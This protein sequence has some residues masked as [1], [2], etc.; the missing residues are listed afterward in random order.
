MPGA[1]IITLWIVTWFAIAYF[2]Y[3]LHF[4]RRI[5]ARAASGESEL[6]SMPTICLQIPLYNEPSHAATCL[7]ACAQI[8]WSVEKIE[9][10]VLDDSNDHTPFLIEEEIQ[11][12][13]A[14]SPRLS[15]KH[16]RRTERVGY[17]AGALDAGLRQ[18]S[19]EFIAIFDCD[20]RPHEAFLQQLMPSLLNDPTVACAQARW[21]FSNDSQNFLTALQNL[22]LNLHFR[23]EHLARSSCG[24]TFNFNG[25]AGIWRR[26][27][28]IDVGGWSAQSVAEDLLISYKA[29][30]RGWRLIY[31]DDVACLSELPSSWSSF[32]IQQRRWSRGNGQVL[33]LLGRSV[34]SA[35]QW[36]PMRRFDCLIHLSGYGVATLITGTYLFTPYWI[37]V[38]VAWIERTHFTEP[39]RMFD[40][41]TYVVLITVIL[42]LF[43][44]KH[45]LVHK[46]APARIASAC[47]LI[48]IAPILV[49]LIAPSFWSGVLHGGF[50]G[51]IFHRTPKGSLVPNVGM[52]HRDRG[53]VLGLVLIA[54]FSTFLAF[55]LGSYGTGFILVAQLLCWI[56]AFQSNMTISRWNQSL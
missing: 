50:S 8:N 24:W 1:A 14:V 47:S 44:S 30:L 21:S 33:R 15:I 23:L 7:R 29:Q 26:D 52:R 13:K 49:L 54:L 48:L 20:F 3:K 27:A 2:A 9:I 17:K 43:A 39:A 40:V 37:A 12:L 41:L 28:L 36:S 53:M 22:L 6:L 35:S 55:F 31:R 18:T 46:A 32:L 11:R 51:N 10:Q 45:L 5:Q 16:L 38:K 19:A 56:Y 42:R 4:W 34:L 25:T